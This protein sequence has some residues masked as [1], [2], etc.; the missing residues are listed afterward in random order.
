[1]ANKFIII[2]DESFTAKQRDQ[3]TKHFKGK[4]AYWHWIGNT[5]L[6]TTK[7]DIHTANSIRDEIKSIIPQG[8]ILV[9]DLNKDTW[10]AFGQKKKFEWMHN[11][12]SKKTESVPKLENT[13]S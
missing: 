2:V 7:K 12:W 11:N 13:N 3:I 4:F 10:S 1:M 6:L 5:W 9:L 8:I